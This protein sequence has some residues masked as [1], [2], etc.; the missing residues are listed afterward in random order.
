MSGDLFWALF[1]H[2]DT[3]GYVNHSD[4]Y[5]LHYP[6]DTPAMRRAAQALRHHAYAMSGLTA[7]AYGIPGP[8]LI[9]GVAG[10][11]VAWRGTA[12]ADRYTV[13]R[14]TKGPGGPWTVACDRCAT[15]NATPWTDASQPAGAG[16]YRVWAY[17][18]SGVSGPYSPVYRARGSANRVVVDDLNSW[19][20]TYS[21]TPNLRF[22]TDVGQFVGGD[23]SVVERTRPTHEEIVWKRAGLTTFRADAYFWPV[24]AVSPFD[25]YT[26]A[27]GAAWTRAAPTITGGNGV[28]KA[29]TYTVS[30]LSHANYVKIR[31]NNTTGSTWSPRLSKVTLTY[32]RL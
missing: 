2:N 27:D 10:G 20:M 4:S 15:D 1:A 11:R 24:E 25:L 3:F 8:P 16:W 17:N 6:G 21:H 30:G 13:E 31:W 7:P 22:A 14:A 26:S 18:L 32:T 5:T 23:T 9:T 19:S 12:V 29:Y 28:W